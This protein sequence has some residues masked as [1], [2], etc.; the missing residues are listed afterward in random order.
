M[1]EGETTQADSV[2]T[3]ATATEAKRYAHGSEIGVAVRA[4]AAE[5]KAEAYHWIPKHEEMG[6]WRESGIEQ[7][8]IEACDKFIS[9]ID[10]LDADAATLT[11]EVG[12]RRS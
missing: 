7:G 6:H 9:L 5:L 11:H 1:S 4:K 12:D 10:A 8:V 2:A 3:D